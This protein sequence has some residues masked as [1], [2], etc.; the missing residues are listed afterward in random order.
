MF[1]M[2]RPYESLAFLFLLETRKVIV[3]RDEIV[4]PNRFANFRFFIV[5]FH[6]IAL[7]AA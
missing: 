4:K 7:S 6:F 2:F 3:I 5:A 1:R